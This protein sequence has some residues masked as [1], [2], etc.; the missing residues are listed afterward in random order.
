MEKLVVCSKLISGSYPLVFSNPLHGCWP[1][2]I[3]L[4]LFGEK[5]FKSSILAHC[6]SRSSLH[7]YSDNTNTKCKRG[8]ALLAPLHFSFQFTHARI[9][10]HVCTAFGVLNVILILF[11]CLRH[12]GLNVLVSSAS[13]F[14]FSKTT[15]GLPTSNPAGFDWHGSVHRNNY[16]NIY[17]TRCNV[18]QFIL[19]GNCC[20]C[21]G[22]YLHPSLGAQTTVSTASGIC[23]TV[24]AV[25]LYRG[26]VGTGL[27]VLWLAWSSTAH[28]N[29]F[30]LF[31]DSGR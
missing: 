11:L 23:H 25:C 9:C 26:R 20:T 2:M 17:Q 19:T 4:Y 15:V 5:M 13:Y 28:S 12:A 30:Q 7:E 31:H 22:W 3:G 10:T 18:T 8:M 27:S 6:S 1:K 14:L 21:F 16:S 24:T 29:Q